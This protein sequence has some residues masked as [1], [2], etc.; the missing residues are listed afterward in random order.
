MSPEHKSSIEAD[1]ALCWRGE[2]IRSV[3]GCGLQTAASSCADLPEV[4]SA[5]AV[6]VAVTHKLLALLG[7]CSSTTACGQPETLLPG[8]RAEG[9]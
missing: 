8:F 5:S 7:P 4:G 2:I 6:E 3:P 1:P 9:S